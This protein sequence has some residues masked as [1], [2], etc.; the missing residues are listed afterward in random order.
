MSPA[1]RHYLTFS[2]DPEAALTPD[3]YVDGYHWCPE[4]DYLMVGSSDSEWGGSEVCC[5]GYRV[6]KNAD[7][8]YEAFE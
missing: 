1:R 8:Y 6:P 2:E 7:L 3:E 4:W 5:C